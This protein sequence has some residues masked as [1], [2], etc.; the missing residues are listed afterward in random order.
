VALNWYANTNFNVMCD[1]VYDQRTDLAP[2]TFS[3]WT[4]GFG[5]EIQFQF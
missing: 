4:N 5:I 3:G 2:G 1:W